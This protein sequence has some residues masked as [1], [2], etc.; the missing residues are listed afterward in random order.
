MGYLRIA[1]LGFCVIGTGLCVNTS[2]AGS[3]TSFMALVGKW[4]ELKHMYINRGGH[5]MVFPPDRT[6]YPFL[7]YLSNS[8]P[9]HPGRM[10]YFY[11]VNGVVKYCDRDSISK[12]ELLPTLSDMIVR[13]RITIHKEH[14]C[15][16]LNLLGIDVPRTF[17][18]EMKRLPSNVLSYE[19]KQIIAD[20]DAPV[21][22]YEEAKPGA[23]VRGPSSRQ[24][25]IPEL[26]S[27]VY[28]NYQEIFNE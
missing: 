13:L 24:G 11:T 21:A 7:T 9:E 4:Y 18:S 23:E 10:R 28:P 17:D 16:E 22:V 8:F 3:A 1:L 12:T 27:V 2:Y 26:G 15:S 5:N 6:G 14:G 20:I 19:S 25:Q